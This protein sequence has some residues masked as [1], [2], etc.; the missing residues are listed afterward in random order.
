MKTKICAIIVSVIML[1]SVLPITTLALGA[2]SVTLVLLNNNGDATVAKEY[3]ESQNFVWNSELDA[4]GNK[5]GID[6]IAHINEFP[7]DDTNL[8]AGYFV[9]ANEGYYIDGVYRCDTDYE[10]ENN[11]LY[12]NFSALGFPEEPENQV[13]YNPQYDENGFLVK[14]LITQLTWPEEHFY[15]SFAKIPDEAICVRTFS[16]LQA[17]LA[18]S[19]VK[20]INIYDD[21]DI[22]ENL[23]ITKS[24]Q[25]IAGNVTV[26]QGV[27]INV[28]GENSSFGASWLTTCDVND[29]SDYAWSFVTNNGT[30]IANSDAEIGQ[31]KENNGEITVGSGAILETCQ[32][33]NVGA[34]IT[35]KSGGELHSVQGS[36]IRNSGTV[37]LEQ[38]A[39]AITW[40]GQGFKNSGS[41]VINGTFNSGYYNSD[42]QNWDVGGFTDDNGAITGSGVFNNYMPNVDTTKINFEAFNG[43]VNNLLDSVSSFAELKAAA[44]NSNPL[45]FINDNIRVTESL[46]LIGKKVVQV[47]WMDDKDDYSLTLAPGVVLSL[48]NSV[49]DGIEIIKEPTQDINISDASTGIKIAS[50]NTILPEN[51]KLKVEKITSG[52]DFEKANVILGD[53]VTGTVLYSITLESE[54]VK[55]Q[56]S[57]KVKVY[58]PVPDG[59]D[60]SKATVYYINSETGSKEEYKVSIECIDNTN[61]IVFETDHFSVY[62]LAMK[63]HVHT[64]V[65]VA[66]NA[67]TADK[68]GNVEYWYCSECGKYFSDAEGKNEITLESTVIAATGTINSPTN[69]QTGGNS[70]LI[71]SLVLLFVSGGTFMTFYATKNYKK[72]KVN[73][74]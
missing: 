43:T 67:A 13:K 41:L 26:A 19:S 35:V 33:N 22:T 66:A 32:I 2:N 69:P 7:F 70:N 27:V 63:V 60:A 10:A 30:I 20:E 21:I 24:V 64:L 23:N 47:A 40:M 53:S 6:T 9:Q 74:R 73:N 46:T 5:T 71:F 25:V 68:A 38:G 57:G 29:D 44:Q 17:A 18:D 54:N 37:I 72:K 58:L 12:G 15:I 42:D 28:S 31:L 16:E 49:I 8:K 4:D 59:F 52:A 55:V 3:S 56:P 62:A 34:T 39:T 65:N 61:Y 51:T 48:Q 45:I 50:D 36:E 14:A 1:L 11:T